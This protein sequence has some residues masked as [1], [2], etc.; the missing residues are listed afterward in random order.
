MAKLPNRMVPYSDAFKAF[1]A[2]DWADYPAGPAEPA[3]AAAYTPARRAGIAGR[4]PADRLVIP[5][6]GLTT[7]SNDTD[8]PYRPHSAFAHLT[9]LGEDFEPDAVLVIEGQAATLFFHARVPR[10]DPE[11]FASARYGEMWVGPRLSLAEVARLTGLTVQDTADLPAAL[12]APLADAAGRLRVVPGVDARTEALVVALRGADAEADRALELRLSELRL[13]KDAFETEQMDLACAA[14]LTGFEAVIADLPEAKRRGR[15]ER[16]VEGVFGLHARHLGN[17]VGYDTIAAAGDH[18]STLHWVR[19]DGNLRDGDLLLLDAGVEV[20]SLYTA[21]I[22]RTL[23]V[24]GHFS[25]AQRQVYAAVLSAQQAGIDAA[26]PGAGFMDVHQAAVRVLAEHLADWGILPVSVEEALAKD[27]G[28]FRRWMVHGT[29]HHL[30]ID[31]H[32][33]AQARRHHYRA[34]KLAPGMI[35]TVEPGLYFKSTDL[36]VPE[37]LRGIGVRIEDDILITEGG[38]RVLSGAFPRDPDAVE[39]WITEIW[40]R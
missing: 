3:P 11:F 17:A 22:T 15:G 5:A 32:D 12:A 34:G 14:T 10:T 7:R 38:A 37:E 31:V 16:W 1:I 27:G 23:P 33:C 39:A 9:G 40:A 2:E 35:I 24:S 26:R 29:S 4:F 36:M 13:I 30:G 18:A 6:G 19:N 8:Y 25:P 21:D 20:D 28:Q